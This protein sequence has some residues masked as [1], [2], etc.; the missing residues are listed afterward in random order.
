MEPKKFDVADLNLREIGVISP[1]ARV[2]R[3]WPQQS[4]RERLQRGV[5]ATVIVIICAVL[6][7]SFLS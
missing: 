7:L 6:V 4:P 1:P 5:F 2:S 3:P